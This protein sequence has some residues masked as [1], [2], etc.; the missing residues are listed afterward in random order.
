MSP[1]GVLKC[2]RMFPTGS[3]DGPDGLTAQY[4]SDMLDENLKLAITEFINLLLNGEL[5]V[6]M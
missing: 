4:I 6:N 5:P 1:E 3:S 2:L